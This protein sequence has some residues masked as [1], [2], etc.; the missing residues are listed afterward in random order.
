M[1]T[2]AAGLALPSEKVRVT[3]MAPS[4]TVLMSAC[5][6]G[7]WVWGCWWLR[8]AGLLPRLALQDKM[9]ALALPCGNGCASNPPFWPSVPALPQVWDCQN[10][11]RLDS[12][13]CVLRLSCTGN[14]W[15]RCE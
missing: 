6:V 4:C 13:P 7:R 8:C 3:A 12:W 15:G 5:T 10:L 1:S 11:S 14:A 9:S 2:G